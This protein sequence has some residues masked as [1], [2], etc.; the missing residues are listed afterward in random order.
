MEAEVD[1]LESSLS[2]GDD[3]LV[4][5]AISNYKPVDVSYDLGG[6]SN[7]YKMI[8]GMLKGINCKEKNYEKLHGIRKKDVDGLDKTKWIHW[9]EY[10]VL[11]AKEASN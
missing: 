8:E 5:V 11:L 2:K 1:T 9:D 7:S 10:R 4:Y 3:K 6:L